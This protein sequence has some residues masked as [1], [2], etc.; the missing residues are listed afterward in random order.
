MLLRA[1]ISLT[2]LLTLAL[3]ALSDTTIVDEDFESYNN[4][5][6]LL[7]AWPSQSGSD[8]GLELVDVN[9][10]IAG[11]DGADFLELQRTNPAGI[12][13]W[14]A[15]YGPDKPRY[16][17]I[18]GQAAQ[19]CGSIVPGLCD[20]SGAGTVNLW[21]G[22]PLI[23]VFPTLTQNVE[24]SVDIGDDA[25]SANKRLT[26]GLR[27]SSTVE[28]IIEMGLYNDPTGFVYR[29]QLF[30]TGGESNPNW[31]EFGD[32][33]KVDNP[34]DPALD[35]QVEVGAGFHTY[36]AVIGI[37]QIVFSLDLYADGVT[38][39][40]TNP[41]PGVGTPGVDA[42]DT[43][44]IETTF[45]GFDDLRIGIPSS[46]PSSGTSTQP[47][48]AFAAF[49]NISLKLVDIPAI[50]AIPEPASATLVLLAAFG[51]LASRRR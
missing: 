39:D 47:G 41:V 37:D 3:P 20:P 6:E 13:A 28:N 48:A 50:T 23:D 14:E 2:L 42:S 4:N 38:N 31:V 36:K 8:N 30:F 29:A 25:L 26:I 1:A 34:L 27:S 9:T 5:T 15:A 17:G 24:L 45:A 44:F 49:D 12:P 16:P 51:L 40:P 35:T 43:V 33:T 46:L 10:V 7:A 21:N 32:A 18:D 11:A 19:F 22:N